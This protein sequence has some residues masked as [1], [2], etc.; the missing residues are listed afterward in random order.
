MITDKLFKWVGGKKWL[1]PKIT[2]IYKNKIKKNNIDYYIEP[3]AGGL[4]SLLFSMP[5]IKEKGIKN[6]VV[7]DINSSLIN[8]Y[9]AL[10]NKKN[11]VFN[12]YFVLEDLYAE[13]IPEK[14]HQLHPTK[15]K[16]ELRKLLEKSSAF[17]YQCRAE[18]N[19]KKET[20]DIRVVA[21]FLF[22]AQHGFNGLYR[23]N[24]SGQYNTPYNWEVR[25]PNKK[26][27]KNTINE[28]SKTFNELNFI[29]EN[30]D[31]FKLIKKYKVHSKKAVFYFDPPYLNEE[32]AE[33]K[34][35]K[36]HFG[37]TEQIKL[38]KMMSELDNVIFSNHM[39]NLFVEYCDAYDFTFESV[40]RA[41]VMNRDV[42][43][44]KD[45][46]EEILA[47]KFSV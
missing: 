4:G 20:N 7:N 40:Y 24:L 3:F 28:Y 33:N 19:E 45:K 25:I 5:T 10:K 34:Y 12:E 35:N 30:K 27:V 42:S 44:R 23:E 8:T 32:I 29:F 43:K 46:I 17:F 47:Y 15:D 6:I 11:K 31:V 21:L 36:D 14:A 9:K 18:Y 13:T 26:K 38:L 41:N 22:L 1:A 39:N 2:Q 16:K 37:R